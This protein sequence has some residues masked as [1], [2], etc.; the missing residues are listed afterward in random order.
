MLFKQDCTKEG[1]KFSV[2]CWKGVNE[3]TNRREGVN[4]L[5][6]MKRE[7]NYLLEVGGRLNPFSNV[8]ET[9]NHLLKEKNGTRS[10]FKSG[11]AA[12]SEINF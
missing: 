5:I 7:V 9:L 3:L 11:G 1:A 8:G 2:K 6:K 12:K 4:Q 10:A